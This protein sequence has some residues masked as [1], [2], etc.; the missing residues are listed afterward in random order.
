M[1]KITIIGGGQSGLQLG[2]GLLQNGYE[3]AVRYPIARPNRSATAASHRAS[4]CSRARST[5]STRSGSSF[6]DDTCPP[7]PGD[8]PLPCRIRRSPA[9]RR[10]IGQPGSTATPSPSPP[11]R[12]VPALHGAIRR[13]GWRARLPRGRHRRTWSDTPTDQRPRSGR[14]RQGRHHPHFERD[15]ERSQFAGADARSRA[16][17]RERHD[18]AVGV[19][20]RRASTSSR[21]WESTSSSRR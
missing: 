13:E 16:H 6:W 9:R 21:A 14:C 20:G 17:V 19:P 4:A 18:A 1:A 12:Q 3:F 10:S 8:R 11:A 7:V 2:I 15:A 5:T